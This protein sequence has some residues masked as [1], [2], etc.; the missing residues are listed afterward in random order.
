M[1]TILTSL[2]AGVP[3]DSLNE[4]TLYFGTE[5]AS[6][7]QARNSRGDNF[8][9]KLL[10]HL[11]SNPSQFEKELRNLV[12]DLYSDHGTANK[13][14]GDLISMD[15]SKGSL[16]KS[17]HNKGPAVQGHGDVNKFDSFR[18][19]LLRSSL[20]PLYEDV[21]NGKTLSSAEQSSSVSSLQD[22]EK[23]S[24]IL[25]KYQ[26]TALVDNFTDSTQVGLVIPQEKAPPLLKNGLTSCMGGDSRTEELLPN[27]HNFEMAESSGR[28][29]L[30]LIN[31][32]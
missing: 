4:L 13:E 29:M 8:S 15:S 9:D 5:G 10:T 21:F 19:T 22:T 24:P 31:N 14:Q 27:L 7:D 1:E 23:A 3:R 25:L 20:E 12:L 26:E 28:V 16:L 32:I 2:K 18:G 30:I 11:S 6:P 17:P